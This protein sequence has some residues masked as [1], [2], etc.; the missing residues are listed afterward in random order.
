MKEYI[1]TR[2]NS[3]GKDAVI[4]TSSKVVAMM[5]SVASAMF[6]SRF[7]TLEEYGTY[8]QLLMAVNLATSF[9]MLGL[10]NSINYF[11]A[12]AETQDEKDQFLSVYYN[13]S[14]ILSVATGLILVLCA[15]L[16]VRYFNNPNINQFIYFL[17]AYPWTRVIM[18]SIENVLIV[19]E[20]AKFLMLF[21][22]SNSL[23]LLAVIVIVQFLG[24]T[25]RQYMILFLMV[26]SLF[27][28]WAYFIVHK[29]I[30]KFCFSI[31]STLLK[32]ILKFSIPIGIASMVGTI[33]L[34][35][36]K[37]VIGRFFD[38]EN[39]AIYTNAGKE[40][41][42]TIFSASIVAVLMPKLVLLLKKGQTHDAIL[43]WGDATTLSYIIICFFSVAF[44]VFAP[45]IMT[46][47][48]SEKYLPGVPVFRVYSIVLLLR[49]TYFGMILNSIGKTKFILYSS[50]GSLLLNGIL[51]YVFLVVFGFTGPA[52]A[53]L[54]SIIVVNGF[55]LIMTGRQINIS[56]KKIFPWKE[57]YKITLLNVAGGIILHSTV[58]VF[59]IGTNL[60]GIL[61]SVVIG[62]IW[63]A[64]YGMICKNL[65]KRKWIMIN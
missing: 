19:S 55:Q 54:V 30:Q 26:E 2:K 3:I 42:I 29:L 38:T 63:L 37:L 4:L 28:I 39:M 14:T 65:I 24:W 11:Y 16:L 33:S 17:A 43:L 56:F 35:M 57:L 7:R 13:L 10:P 44:V 1:N 64:C 53:T 45:Q 47:L 49:V 32:S 15:P 51:N 46:I 52:W 18:S 22:I 59:H 31:D 36:D 5:I 58:R 34:E 8:S 21:R 41:P 27:A 25:F 6:L 50:I 48:Y 40:L 9:V 20:K 61:F 23:A 12:K 60:K 62:I